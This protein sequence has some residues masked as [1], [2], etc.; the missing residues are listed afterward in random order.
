MMNSFIVMVKELIWMERAKMAETNRR[1]YFIVFDDLDG[2]MCP[3]FM[4]VNC[5]LSITSFDTAVIAWKS[6]KGPHFIVLHVNT[7]FDAYL[8]KN[9]VSTENLYTRP[10]G[11]FI[12]QLRYN[13]SRAVPL[14]P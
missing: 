5:R 9:R 13:T 8:Q 10:L 14:L 6:F 4:C 1:S 3:F 7:C 2:E 12:D 11:S